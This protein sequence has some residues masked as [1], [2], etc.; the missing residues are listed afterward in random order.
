M[1]ESLSEEIPIAGQPHIGALPTELIAQIFLE[2]VEGRL[3]VDLKLS[4]WNPRSDPQ[5]TLARVCGAWRDVALSTPLLWRSLHIRHSFAP[6]DSV[7][8]ARLRRVL[9]LQLD[10]AVGAPLHVSFSS[11]YDEDFD[12]RRRAQRAVI[13]NA[14]FAAT[15]RW[16]TADLSVAENEMRILHNLPSDDPFPLLRVLKLTHNKWTASERELDILS[17]FQSN[18]NA[19]PNLRHVGYSG[20]YRGFSFNLLLQ[21]L[22]SPSF[23]WAQITSLSLRTVLASTATVARGLEL[24]RPAGPAL[25][26]LNLAEYQLHDLDDISTENLDDLIFDQLRSLTFSNGNDSILRYIRAPR[27]ESFELSD[28][29]GIPRDTTSADIMAFVSHAPQL[30]QLRLHGVKMSPASLLEILAG[31]P[32]LQKL[33]VEN[34]YNYLP[35]EVV[36]ALALQPEARAARQEPSEAGS[37]SNHQVPSSSKF[38]P[39]VPQL[40]HLELAGFE[41][42]GLS[43]TEAFVSLVRSRVNKGLRRVKFYGSGLPYNLDDELR[44]EGFGFLL[45]VTI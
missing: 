12:A 41:K 21:H 43:S 3:N 39:L 18:H 28:S 17:I 30:V 27:L 38:H 23:P 34:L 32:A 24:L 20:G 11:P 4:W 44:N 37:D 29:S 13:V 10:R 9:K 36:T 33:V 25:Q 5:W 35:V 16:E 15:H 19:P 40:Q 6:Y 31:I 2:V 1:E 8:V 14:L 45:Y 26:A 7:P 42:I 22:R